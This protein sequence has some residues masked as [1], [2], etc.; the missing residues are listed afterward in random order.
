MIIIGSS[1]LQCTA[2]CC[3]VLQCVAACYSV[4]Q[5]LFERDIFDDYTMFLFVALCHSVLQCAAVS[6]WAWFLLARDISLTCW[7]MLT[8]ADTYHVTSFEHARLPHLYVTSPTHTWHDCAYVCLVSSICDMTYSCITCCMHM[9]DMLHVVCICVTCPIYT[10]RDVLI[11]DMMYLYATWRLHRWHDVFIYEKTYSYVT[12]RIRMWHDVLVCDMTY[13][14]VKWR[15]RMW[16]DVFICDVFIYD[17][18][19]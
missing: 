14:Y 2:V 12:W 18:T 5:C 8:H 13:S 11:C 7:H 3:S 9:C 15:I 17:V 6:V 4:L 1:L 16:H 10:R 19:Y